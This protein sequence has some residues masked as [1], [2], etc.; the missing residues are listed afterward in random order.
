MIGGLR[1]RVQLQKL[2][3]TSDGAGGH[4]E[5]WS[6]FAFVWAELTPRRGRETLRADKPEATSLLEV[7]I[8]HRL[9]VT[10]SMRL[11]SGQKQFEILSVA[12]DQTKTWLV[13][14]CLEIV[15]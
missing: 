5:T 4:G 13:C 10:P 6:T 7:R 1:S 11:A 15:D 12:D 9:D 14:Q 8:R 3:R 2:T